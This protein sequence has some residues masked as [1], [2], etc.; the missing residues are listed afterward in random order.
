MLQTSQ[1][2]LGG[3]WINKLW[4]FI[5]SSVIRKSKLWFMKQH[6]KNQSPYWSKEGSHKITL[7]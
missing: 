7:T 3:E 6:D 2:P 5:Q 4:M 1:C